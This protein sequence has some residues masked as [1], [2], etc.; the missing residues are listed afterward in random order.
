MQGAEKNKSLKGLKGVDLKLRAR[1]A[2][3]E[4]N[5]GQELSYSIWY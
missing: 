4:M 1:G 3:D 5:R 2:L